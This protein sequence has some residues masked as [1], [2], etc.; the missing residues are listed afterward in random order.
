M[1]QHAVLQPFAIRGRDD[2]GVKFPSHDCGMNSARS[3]GTVVMPFQITRIE[4]DTRN[5]VIARQPTQPLF[6]LEQDALALAEFDAARIGED[7][8]FDAEAHGFCTRLPN[9]LEV[10]FI[11]EEV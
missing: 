3:N 8:G 11:V 4:I 9:G 5:S 2:R 6:E 1:W 10:R 7:S